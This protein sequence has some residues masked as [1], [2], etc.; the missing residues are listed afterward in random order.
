MSKGPRSRWDHRICLDS[1]QIDELL[2]NRLEVLTSYR[3][4]GFGS[5]IK[6]GWLLGI[7]EPWRQGQVP[8]PPTSVQVA[9]VTFTCDTEPKRCLARDRVSDAESSKLQPREAITMPSEMVELVVRVKR[10]WSQRLWTLQSDDMRRAGV[11]RWAWDQHR[12]RRDNYKTFDEFRN[13]VGV[14]P[15]AV[16]AAL[17]NETD[18]TPLTLRENHAFS[19]RVKEK[20][21]ENEIVNLMEIERVE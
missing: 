4:W 10:T 12:T 7:N 17:W 5:P 19:Y 18:D 1:W 8:C 9:H 21:S 14:E 2:E 20:W 16:L 13:A 3:G 6:I 15:L 11:L